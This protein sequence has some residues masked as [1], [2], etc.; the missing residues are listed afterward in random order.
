MAIAPRR[1][2]GHHPSSQLPLPAV[3]PNVAAAVTRR[4]SRR[5]S[6]G[7]CLPL[8]AFATAV[9]VA[10][11]HSCHH[12]LSIGAVVH[13]PPIA[14]SSA[15]RS[16]CILRPPPMALSPLTLSPFPPPPTRSCCMSRCPPPTLA[17]A[18]LFSEACHLAGI[19]FPLI[20]CVAYCVKVPRKRRN[21]F[22]H[23]RMLLQRQK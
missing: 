5:C 3:S 21:G 2:R 20:P 15:A 7:L 18:V 16:Y 17:A 9:A 6:S 19:L 11:R 12:Q 23:I 8:P 4:H 1:G 14:V 10:R 22:R 13:P